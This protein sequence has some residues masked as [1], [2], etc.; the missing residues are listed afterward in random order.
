MVCWTEGHSTV[1]QSTL[2]TERGKHMRT[3]YCDIYL[4]FETLNEILLALSIPD[5]Q[6]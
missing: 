4:H 2:K 5:I 6:T 1:L 3:I